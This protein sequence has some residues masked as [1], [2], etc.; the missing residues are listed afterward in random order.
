M[1]KM[2]NKYRVQADKAYKITFGVNQT[3]KINKA[4]NTVDE[5]PMG[6]LKT[7]TIEN[8]KIIAGE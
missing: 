2:Q 3:Q 8:A 7:A 4:A 1:S 6:F 5:T